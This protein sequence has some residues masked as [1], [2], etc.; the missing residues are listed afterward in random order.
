MDGQPYLNLF[1][2]SNPEGNYSSGTIVDDGKIAANLKIIT[3][4]ALSTT[5]VGTKI[6]ISQ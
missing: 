1:T 5:E 2:T 3:N 4:A 6:V